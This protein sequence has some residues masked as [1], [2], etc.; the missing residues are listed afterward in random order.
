MDWRDRAACLEQNPELFFPIGFTGAALM[1]LEQAKRVCGDCSVR[2]ECLRWA[3][4]LG[5]DHGVWGGASEEERRSIKRR[6]ARARALN[7]A[8]AAKLQSEQHA[9][10]FDQD[11]LEQR[12]FEQH[13]VGRQQAPGGGT[14]A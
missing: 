10:Q 14:A 7:R 4:E 1:Q 8:K 6:A 9:A 12:S 3:L 5:L 2:E 11:R 13:S